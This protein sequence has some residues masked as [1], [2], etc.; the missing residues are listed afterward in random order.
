MWIISFYFNDLWG[1]SKAWSS[2]FSDVIWSI[3][4]RN[5][6]LIIRKGFIINSSIIR[7]LLVRNRDL[8]ICGVI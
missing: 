7:S 6:D 8:M 5:R 4:V 1:H 3:L 2:I